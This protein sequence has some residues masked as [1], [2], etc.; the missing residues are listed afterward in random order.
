MSSTF[1]MAQINMTQIGYLD[2]PA[3]HFTEL[4][5]IWGYTD[6]DGNEY[7]IVGCNDGTSICDISNPAIP[8]EIVWI[9]GS[10]SVWRDIKT[11]G[12]YAYVTTEASDG[13]LII[14]LT[15]LPGSTSLPTNYYFGPSGNPWTSAHD[16]YADD[17]GYAYIAGADRDNGGI[18]ILDV[19]TDPMNP[20]EVGVFDDWYAH[21]AF[22]KD[23][24]AYFS[25]VFEGFFSIVDVTN[26]SAP[27]LINTVPTPGVLTHNVWSSMD[28]NFV[29]A[30][31]EIADGFVS[32]YDVTDPMSVTMLD[33]IQSS[34]GANIIPHN[35]HLQGHYVVTSYYTD[36]V[37]IFDV[38]D[39]AAMTEA[40][41]FDTSPGFSGSTYN[42]CWGVYP[43]F[44]S[45]MIIASDTE[46]GLYVLKADFLFAA[47][48]NGNV[49]D[50]DTGLP[51][52]GVDID[53]VGVTE[54]GL[55]DAPGDYSIQTFTEGTFTADFTKTGYFPESA[56]VTL[57]NGTIT[58]QDMQMD[59]ISLASISDETTSTIQIVPNPFD[60]MIQI[61]GLQSGTI[62]V[63]DLSG[64]LVS[65]HEFQNEIDLSELQSG[66][67]LIS[68]FNTQG[69]LLTTLKQVKR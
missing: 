23:D 7:A 11:S 69:E 31:D 49:T 62:Q 3:L 12:D 51:I 41:S 27:V 54:S 55:T 57:T 13:L 40:G 50:I 36:G 37:V 5:D 59:K 48:L 25:N 18:I 35:A 67:Y 24:T 65:I 44:T 6:E 52:D 46:E 8:V 38:S 56:T 26:K 42:G 9:P 66:V 47:Y 53:I 45:E 10:N 68:V 34:P 20:I 30:T 43:Y 14:D 1:L 15:P 33:Q 39:P 63:Q 17:N 64:R 2:I 29:F 32:S 61:S 21:D 58:I 19:M 16:V 28:G 4:N 22:V 60:D